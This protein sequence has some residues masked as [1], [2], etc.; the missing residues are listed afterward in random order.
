MEP[1]VELS[2][3]EV[4]ACA[5]EIIRNLALSD[6]LNKWEYDFGSKGLRISLKRGHPVRTAVAKEDV[7]FGELMSDRTA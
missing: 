3:N 2:P 4:A 7:D 6:D 1:E 5:V